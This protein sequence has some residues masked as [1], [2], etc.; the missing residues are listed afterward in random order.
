MIVFAIVCGKYEPKEVHSL[1]ADPELAEQELATLEGDW[2]IIAWS[3]GTRERDFDNM[4]FSSEMKVE[5]IDHVGSDEDIA[6]AAWVST[7]GERAEEGDP[8]RIAGLINMLMRD[9][10][11]SPFEQ[12]LMRFRVSAPIVVFREHHRHRIASYNEMSGR[13]VEMKPKFYVPP[14][15]RPLIQ[16]GKPGQYV[17]ESGT[18]LQYAIV[19]DAFIS[20]AKQQWHKYQS[21]LHNG[22]AKEVARDVLPLSLYSNMVVA[23]NPRALMNFLSLRVRSENTSVPTFPMWEIEQLGMRYETEFAERFPLTW[24]AFND[25]GRVAP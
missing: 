24:K 6:R 4:E 14:R 25:N 8:K 1:W 11:G 13:Y 20:T 9:R 22:I 12:G 10:H 21:M 17:F 16:K 18:D 2:R 19:S 23:M 15:E 5:Y 7:L 3:M